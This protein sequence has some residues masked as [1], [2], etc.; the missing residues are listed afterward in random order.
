[1]DRFFFFF[2]LNKKKLFFFFFKKNRLIVLVLF[3]S[4]NI[5]FLGGALKIIELI[6]VG[7][8]FF[9]FGRGRGLKMLKQCRS[10]IINLVVC[11]LFF[12]DVWVGICWDVFE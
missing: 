6:N 7:I 2:L 12:G 9:F 8:L 3:F 11:V 1:M 10:L 4:M 5:F